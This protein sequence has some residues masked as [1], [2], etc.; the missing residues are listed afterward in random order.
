MHSYVVATHDE[1]LAEQVALTLR[2]EGARV[3][4][5]C[6]GDE[7]LFLVDRDSPDL[8]VLDLDLP[9]ISGLA[10]LELL[11]ADPATRRLPVI[12]ISHLRFEEAL[13]ALHLGLAAYMTKPVAGEQIAAFAARVLN[14]PA[15][16]PRVA[17]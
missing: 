14:S 3:G 6:D 17:A 1:E 10:V 2:R 11:R 5:A 9:M 16:R 13:G 7:A 15:P 4:L 12:A 8:L